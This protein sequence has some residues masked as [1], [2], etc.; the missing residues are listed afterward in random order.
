MERGEIPSPKRRASSNGRRYLRR[1]VQVGRGKGSLAKSPGYKNRIC[2][3]GGPGK[4][5][6][7]AKT[8]DSNELWKS[9][10]KSETRFPCGAT[11]GRPETRTR[12][13][14]ARLLGY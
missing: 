4:S 11:D 6:R 2:G 9:V 3:R 10:E 12:Q 13:R 14:R 7:D 1:W 8:A 5:D